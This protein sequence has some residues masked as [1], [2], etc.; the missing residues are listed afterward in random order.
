MQSVCE[1]C[2]RID[3]EGVIVCRV[4]GGPSFCLDELPEADD[5]FELD[6]GPGAA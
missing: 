5:D 2:G 4:C 6:E 1:D 3:L